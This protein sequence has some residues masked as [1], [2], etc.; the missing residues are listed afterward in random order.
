MRLLQNIARIPEI[1]QLW[2]D[3]L[4]SPATLAPSFTGLGRYMLQN[5]ARIPEIEQ[6]K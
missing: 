6:L 1:E 5:I 3:I 4:Y 2:Q